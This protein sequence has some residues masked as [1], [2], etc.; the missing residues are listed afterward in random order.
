MLN[1][2]NEHKSTL[3]LLLLPSSVHIKTCTHFTRSKRGESVRAMRTR[4]RVCVRDPELFRTYYI[5]ACPQYQYSTYNQHSSLSFCVVVA[6]LGTKLSSHMPCNWAYVP[7]A[8][9]LSLLQIQQH[10]GLQLLLTNEGRSK[11]RNEM[12]WN[13]TTRKCTQQFGR[14]IFQTCCRVR[15]IWALQSQDIS[16]RKWE[17]RQ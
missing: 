8:S 17:K 12:E 5:N 14:N 15:S 16:L 7:L 2:G 9:S 13:E 11:N 3:T 10:A 1:G 4:E 6:F